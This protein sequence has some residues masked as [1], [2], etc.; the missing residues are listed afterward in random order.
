MTRTKRI[1][2]SYPASLQW[3]RRGARWAEIKPVEPDPGNAGEG[4]V[5]SERMPN[6]G[7]DP[8]PERFRLLGA[9]D[10]FLL[11]GNLGVSLLVIVIGSFLVPSLSLRD[12]LIAIL[13]G[14]LIG[15]VML[16]T[17]GL[18]GADAR[19][20]GMVLM[21]APLGRVGS[22][23]PTV[24]N[25]LQCLGWATFEI[26]IIAAAAAALS[27]ELL[28]FGGQAVWTL[29]FGAVA[30]VLALVG[31]VG[32]VRRFI[33]KF[34][35]YFVLISLVYLTWWALDTASVR[36]LWNRQGEG[37]TTIWLGMDLVIAVTVSWVP[38]IP[39]Y[40][41]FS[42][43]RRS[44]FVGAGLGYFFAGSWMLALGAIVVLTRGVSEPTQLPAA[45][46][47][48]GLTAALALLAITVDE[49]DEAFANVYSSG[50]SAQNVLA[51]VPQRA[52]VGGAAV[53]AT[54]T[55]LVVD[56]REYQTFLL[57]LGAFFVPLFGVLLAHW[58][59]GGASYSERDIFASP[60]V[61]LELLTAWL[62]GFLVYQWL[63][64]IGPTWWLD[65]VA[66]VRPGT[67]GL[68][69]IGASVPSFL[70]SF[71]LATLAVAVTRTRRGAPLTRRGGLSGT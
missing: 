54:L 49:T 32:V 25:V 21:R 42:R 7:I 47:A 10:Q 39:D 9:L 50:V 67:A 65:A 57:L 55:A 14:S 26:I 8:V 23:A 68:D 24:L 20:P 1:G 46:A 34:A 56:L 5:M 28:G 43:D 33:R 60:T 52:L 58:L 51:G 71:A 4:S 64:P 59:L 13:L 62:A 16:G 29:V 22:F 11:W 31:P 27:D 15:N 17:A 40:S 6:W 37:G 44:A 30:A 2:Q 38:L 35:V 12:A 45:V 19:V 61:R 69:A 63:V 36:E 70:A 41:R 48:A 66:E 3:K 53:I 18:I